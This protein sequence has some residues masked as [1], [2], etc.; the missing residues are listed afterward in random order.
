MAKSFQGVHCRL[1]KCKTLCRCERQHPAN[2]RQVHAIRA[3]RWKRISH[4]LFAPCEHD[5]RST[6][7]PGQVS[8]PPNGYELSGPANLRARESQPPA[9]SA[10]ASFSAADVAVSPDFCS[11]YRL[12][13]P[14]IRI[15]QNETDFIDS[16][17]PRETP[18]AI[19]IGGLCEAA[20]SSCRGSSGMR[21]S[22]AT[23]PIGSS[24]ISRVLMPYFLAVRA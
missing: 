9:G 5:N 16:Q 8:C 11:D 12:D 13:L 17:L 3:M 23:P 4:Q 21:S 6:W 20:H 10:P 1:E 14:K 19:S 18:G 22:R 24:V 7:M 2:Q 15:S